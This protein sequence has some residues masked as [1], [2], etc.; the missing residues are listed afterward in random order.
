MALI[1]RCITL[2]DAYKFKCVTSYL[3]LLNITEITHYYAK[4]K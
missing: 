1:K 2:E 4:I 3:Y